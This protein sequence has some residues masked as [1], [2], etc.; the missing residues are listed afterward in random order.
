MRDPFGNGLAEGDTV[1][2]P[3]GAGQMFI[4]TVTKITAG[5]GAPGTPEAVSQVQV[6]FVIPLFPD[7]AGTVGGIVRV[8][9]KTAEAESTPS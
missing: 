7:Q 1:G 2:F 9:P 6:T 8:G 3:I 4:G 5:L